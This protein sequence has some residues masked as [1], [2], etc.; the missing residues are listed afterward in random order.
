MK[1]FVNFAVGSNL[2]FLHPNDYDN[3]AED[4][5][6]GLTG[7]NLVEP[8]K[9]KDWSHI[10]KGDGS[11]YW[12]LVVEHNYDKLESLKE[13]DKIIYKKVKRGIETLEALADSDL[14]I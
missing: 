1:Y 11:N 6:L 10:I 12:K 7:D 9:S 4:G 8:F 2:Q 13:D 3:K 5:F 14:S